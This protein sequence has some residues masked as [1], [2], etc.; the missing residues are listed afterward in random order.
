MR[1]QGVFF[2][3]CQHP[4]TVIV[5]EKRGPHHARKVCS[6]CHKF[7]GWIPKPENVQRLRRNAE[8][9]TAL[10]KLD[11]LPDW[12]RGFIRYLSSHKNITP[13]QQDELLLLRDRYLPKDTA[14]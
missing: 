12:E 11:N 10:S 4:R 6:D 8:I 7:L 14:A 3:E 13:K 1:V 9:L 5:P 2:G